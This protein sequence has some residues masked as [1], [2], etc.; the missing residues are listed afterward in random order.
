MKEL[1]QVTV[2]FSDCDKSSVLVVATSI[3]QAEEMACALFRDDYIII[4]TWAEKVD[5]VFGYKVKLEPIK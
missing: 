4:Q 3:K 2:L 1:Y 5:T